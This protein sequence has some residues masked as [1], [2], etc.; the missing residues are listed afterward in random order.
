MFYMFFWF[1][2][3]LYYCLRRI[4]KSGIILLILFFIA[5]LFIFVKPSFAS[6]TI[7]EF[8][9]EGITYTLP[10]P[11]TVNNNNNSYT[12][13]S[14]DNKTRF[15]IVEPYD[16]N[17]VLC[18]Y[19]GVNANGLASTNYYNVLRGYYN[20][21]MANVYAYDISYNNGTWGTWSQRDFTSVGIK[22][23]ENY[24]ASSVPDG[25]I[26]LN[27]TYVYCE[28]VGLINPFTLPYGIELTDNI[29]LLYKYD[30]AYLLYCSNNDA[31]FKFDSSSVH[32]YCRTAS[33]N[34][35]NF[36]VYIYNTNTH[37]WVRQ[38]SNVSSYN[39]GMAIEAHYQYF[40]NKIMNV[41][42]IYDIG[43]HDTFD[44]LYTEPFITDTSGLSDFS[45][46]Y[47][48]INAGILPTTDNYY[49]D[50]TYPV[51]STYFSQNIND[52]IRTSNG[53]LEFNLPRS[54]FT[55]NFL[56]TNGGELDL[57]L[58]RTSTATGPTQTFVYNLGTYT[59]AMQQTDIDNINNSTEFDQN[60]ELS[61]NQKETTD[62]VN[63]LTN[64]ITDDN[65]DDSS[66]YLPQDN[67]NDITADGLNGIFTS[68]YNAFCTGTAQ[69]IV[70]P[71]PFT[72]KN[73]TL[74]ANYVRTMLTNS[75]ATWIITIIEA[76]WW[77]LISRYIIKDITNKIT[78]IKSGN[79]EDIEQSNIKGDML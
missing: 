66:I 18:T 39:V 50:F 21:S 67:S 30:K 58:V 4:F 79:I 38:A 76:F 41:D 1:F 63:N 42:T 32:F 33:N 9:F 40:T 65:I 69:D 77:Y 53:Y 71:I 14:Y 57:K 75:N 54:M 73:I 17:G 20:N 5:F 36:D 52:Y 12:I 26:E 61:D 16:I 60:K 51:S 44:Y 43:Y 34:T 3:Q 70:F 78:K 23:K 48:N 2:K 25:I 72:N 19:T 64:T 6:T 7:D 27:N 45:F 47:I 46:S 56:I 62:A 49:I 8:T 35:A 55:G 28:G 24:Q 37:T 11:F 13:L 22:W 74:P 31:Y 29:G 15:R 59:T 68:I 10:Q